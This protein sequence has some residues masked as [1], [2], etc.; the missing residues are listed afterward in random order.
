MFD[1]RM[2]VRENFA[3]FRDSE[4][5]KVVY[6]DSFDNCEFNVRFGTIESTEDLGT[7]EAE[8]DDALNAQLRELICNKITN[9][10]SHK[11]DHSH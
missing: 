7:I 10:K 11:I 4:T 3:S 1:F 2:T 6:V 9:N 5:G 8:N